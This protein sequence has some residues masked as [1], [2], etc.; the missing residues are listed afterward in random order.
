VPSVF[1]VGAVQ[2]RVA[3]PVLDAADTAIANAA[4]EAD[5]PFESVTVITMFEV[6]PVALGVP[7]KAPVV[8]LNVAQ[9]GL[10]VIEKPNVS[11]FASDALGLKLYA[12]PTTAEVDGVPVMVG[13]VL[14]ELDVVEEL[15][16]EVELEVE[17]VADE[18]EEDETALGDAVPVVPEALPSE[19]PPPQPA[20]AAQATPINVHEANSMRRV[21]EN[22]PPS[23]QLSPGPRGRELS[24]NRRARRLRGKLNSGVAKRIDAA[25]IV[26]P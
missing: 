12:A 23:L 11:P 2:L 13:A 14:L 25:L 24:W 17:L 18:A 3:E 1:C 5:A 8:V 22:M 15:E 9:L 26:A 4:N 16:L 21:F 20:S 19:P 6:V 7:V 10:L